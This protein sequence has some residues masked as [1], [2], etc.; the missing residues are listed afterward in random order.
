MIYRDFLMRIISP[1]HRRFP[2]FR[3]KR[4]QSET[5]HKKRERMGHALRGSVHCS[6]LHDCD[7]FDV[8]VE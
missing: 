2:P 7:L 5:G 4:V 6:M 3:K 1:G 8:F